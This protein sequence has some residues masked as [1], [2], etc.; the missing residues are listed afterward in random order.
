MAYS[1]WIQDQ[2]SK[3]NLNGVTV[4]LNAVATS[5]RDNSKGRLMIIP[6]RVTFDHKIHGGSDSENL[7]FDLVYTQN[8]R[9][10]LAGTDGMK[11]EDGG[12]TDPQTLTATATR[13]SVKFLGFTV[14]NED[15]SV[16]TYHPITLS[17]TDRQKYQECYCQDWEHSGLRISWQTTRTANSGKCICQGTGKDHKWLFRFRGPVTVNFR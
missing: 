13:E 12:G 15:G 17:D 4:T 2:I 6:I 10:S 3:G 9:T 11:Q 1:P 16:N 14:L 7:D 5:T 8:V